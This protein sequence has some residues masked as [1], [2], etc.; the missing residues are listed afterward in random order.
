MNYR[1]LLA[2]ILLC[3]MAIKATAQSKPKVESFKASPTDIISSDQQRRDLNKKLCALLKVQVLDE[4]TE[5]SGT[6]PI[7]ELVKNGAETW[8]YL[9]ERTKFV[10]LMFKN[11]LP[12][13]VQ[14]KNHGVTSLK[15]NTVYE[16]VVTVPVTAAS[17][18]AAIQQVKTSKLTIVVKPANATI[19]LEGESM[20][21]REYLAQQN[22]RLELTLPREAYTYTITAPDYEPQTGEFYLTN[23]PHTEQVTLR[24]LMGALT[25]TCETDRA[26]FVV[27]GQSIDKNPKSTFWVGELPHGRHIVEVRR[28]GYEPISREVNVL[29]TQSI[30]V[31]FPPLVKAKKDKKSLINLKSKRNESNKKAKKNSSTSDDIYITERNEQQQ[32]PD[33]EMEQP[34]IVSAETQKEQQKAEKAQQK[35]Q[36]KAE[37][38]RQKAEKKAEEDQQKAQEKADKMLRKTE[39]AQQQKPRGAR[40]II[41]G[42]RAGAGMSTMA[43]DAD[44][45]VKSAFSWQAGLGADIRLSQKFHLCP[46]LL[47][48][49][50]GYE[51]EGDY[52]Y[53]IKETT[54]AS[55]LMLPVQLAFRPGKFQIN[56]GPY[57][58][59][60]IGGKIKTDS[61]YIDNTDT[62]DYYELFNYGLAV[63]VGF[64]LGKHF[65]LGANYELGLGD[66]ANR[67]IAV[68]LGFNF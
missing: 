45:D 16:L 65:Y 30:T 60:G 48:A 67:N 10:K 41:L 47:Y 50:R 12:L 14:F 37:K 4:I 54:T 51:Y 36:E 8:I 44:G 34:Y 13:T 28:E 18:Q 40:P 57:V 35:A 25:I 1:T 43:V 31:S 56:A 21:K 22:G 49:Q 24:L 17:T 63:G 7:G 39:K 23:Q 55:F 5:V 6:P 59:Y 52:Y 27:D 9:P 42:L 64:N 61:Y 3:A 68:S 29:P 38:A 19:T 32:Q 33:D 2:I 62:F 26:E 66:Y 53:D 20:Q 11:N 58:A 46:S 15:S